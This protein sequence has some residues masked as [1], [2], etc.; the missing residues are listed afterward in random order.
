MRQTELAQAI[1]L[2]SRLEDDVVVTAWVATK[3]EEDLDGCLGMMHLQCNREGSSLQGELGA[4]GGLAHATA[5]EVGHGVLVEAAGGGVHQLEMCCGHWHD[6]HEGKDGE[7]HCDGVED[8]R[9]EE[10]RDKEGGG[11]R[12]KGREYGNENSDSFVQYEKPKLRQGPLVSYRAEMT[13]A[14]LTL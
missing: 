10:R 4:V 6:G 14:I 7:L 5:G 8:D 11:W 1:D 3:R 2:E 9:G 12:E 13:S